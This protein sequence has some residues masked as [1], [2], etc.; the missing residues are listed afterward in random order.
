MFRFAL[1]KQKKTRNMMKSKFC[2]YKLFQG[3]E[4]AP[5]DNKKI[6]ENGVGSASLEN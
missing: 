5:T 4:N 3:V 2:E 6:G 1:I